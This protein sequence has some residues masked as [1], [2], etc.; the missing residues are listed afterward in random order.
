MF[1]LPLGRAASNPAPQLPDSEFNVRT[2]RARASASDPP[3]TS[4]RSGSRKLPIHTSFQVGKYLVTSQADRVRNGLYR[5][6]VSIRSGRG[7]ATSDRIVRFVP[8]FDSPEAAVRYASE[9]GHEWLRAS[10]RGASCPF[11]HQE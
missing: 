3:L 5:A 2:R 8:D 7:S 9:Q 11:T 4:P 6:C 10:S 1:W